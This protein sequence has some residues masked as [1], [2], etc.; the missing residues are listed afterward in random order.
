MLIRAPFA[1]RSSL[2]AKTNQSVR[3]RQEDN[4]PAG[5]SPF[6]LTIHD[7]AQLLPLPIYFP[8]FSRQILARCTDYKRAFVSSLS[9]TKWSAA[10]TSIFAISHERL[11]VCLYALNACFL[12]AKTSTKQATYRLPVKLSP[13]PH[14]IK[15]ANSKVDHFA[16]KAAL[17]LNQSQL[18]QLCR[19]PRHCH[20]HCH[21]GPISGERYAR[22]STWVRPQVDPIE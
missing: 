7:L 6:S 22:F 18:C 13:Q 2:W 21:L 20:R 3:V 5:K 10:K 17:Q 19:C 15:G 16:V 12:A 11:S 14:L 8:G 1:C 4:L 9:H